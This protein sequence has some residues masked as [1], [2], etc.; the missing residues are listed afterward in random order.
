MNELM[1]TG[2]IDALLTRLT[3]NQIVTNNKVAGF[4]LRLSNVEEVIKKDIYLTNSQ[5]REVA[6]QVKSKVRVICLEK[7]YDYRT[8][9]KFLFHA[10]YS[11]INGQYNVMS[12]RELP[13]MFFTDIIDKIQAWA[14]TEEFEKRIA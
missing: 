13:R 6:R 2:K 4:E 3:E 7:G 12:Y 5:L 9:S 10:I 11:S 1:E 8:T 14:P